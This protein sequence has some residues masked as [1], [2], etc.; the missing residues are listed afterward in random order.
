M[1]ES[2]VKGR[3]FA[4]EHLKHQYPVDLVIDSG[5]TGLFLCTVH[6]FFSPIFLSSAAFPKS[7]TSQCPR[8]SDSF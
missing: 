8:P 3:L 6:P 4:T 5:R 7:S 2:A 1:F